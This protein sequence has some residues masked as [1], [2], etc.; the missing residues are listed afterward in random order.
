MKEAMFWQSKAEG[1]VFCELCPKGCSIREGHKGF[2]RV[3]ENRGGVLYTLN[4]GQ[5]SSYALD[6]VEKKPLYHF[7]PDTVILSL[8]TVGCNLRCGFCQNWQIAQGE[9]QTLDLSPHQAVDLAKQQRDKGLPCSGIAYTY[10]EPFM[11]YEYIYDTARLA[12]QAGLRNVLVTN[13]YVQ[14]EPLQ[15]LL[16]YIDAMNIDVKG[17]T[18][19]Y[20]QDN[21]LGH[22]APVLKT[23]ETAYKECHVEITILLVPGLN[24]S[25][26]EVQ[27]LVDWL[28]GLDPDMPV[29]FSRYFPNYQFALPPTPK[30]TLQRAYQLAKRKLHYVYL[31]NLGDAA[32]QHTLCPKCGEVIIRREGY[33]TQVT[34]LKDKACGHCG[35]PIR[36]VP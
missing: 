27:A 20:Y 28:A 29:H 14:Q 25:E 8:G 36:M 6:P 26:E 3:R 16:P 13:G 10:S 2:C 18:D 15:K 35:N 21:C 24:D 22:L 5:V 11:W 30:A 17:F 33:R 9:P 19:K 4:Y 23:V 32:S 7:Y 12:Q 34:G 31:G 1:L